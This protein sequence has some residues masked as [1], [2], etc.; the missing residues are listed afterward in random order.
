M[1][2]DAMT[3][4]PSS[5]ASAGRFRFARL[6]GRQVKEGPVDVPVAGD[7]DERILVL[8]LEF[9]A[10][11]GERLLAPDDGD[12]GRPGPAPQVELPERLGRPARYPSR[13]R[14]SRPSRPQAGRRSGRLPDGW[15]RSVPRSIAVAFAAEDLDLGVDDVARNVVFLQ[16]PGE[17]LDRGLEFL[18]DDVVGAEA[19]ELVDLRGVAGPDDDEEARD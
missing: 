17:D 8:D 9:R 19:V 16:D 4:W 10:R 6:A 11:A 2:G 13:R 15:R 5:G 7:E 14:K 3:A 18:G 1:A 12:D